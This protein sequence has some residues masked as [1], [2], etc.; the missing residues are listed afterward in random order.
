MTQ[1]L[2]ELLAI[3]A[4]EQHI[5]GFARAMDDHDWETLRGIMADDVRAE[6]GEG[7]LEG[8][9]AVIDLIRRYLERCGVT[10]HLIGNIVVSVSG[11]SATSR[12]YVRDIH[13]PADNAPE[14]F[15][16]LGD[17]H[18][19]WELR[20]SAWRMVERIKH[21]RAHVGSVERAFGF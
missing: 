12:A 16:T 10:Q 4:I 18:D 3:R 1:S 13:L 6:M 19:R 5:I 8:P 7:P 14:P 21:N 17:Y 15:Y 9:Q 2:E 20:D 11:A